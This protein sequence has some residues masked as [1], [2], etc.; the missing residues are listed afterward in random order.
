MMYL[1]AHSHGH[2]KAPHFRLLLAAGRLAPVFERARYIVMAAC[3]YNGLWSKLLYSG[4]ETWFGPQHLGCWDQ[5]TYA[6]QIHMQRLFGERC[7]IKHID[8]VIR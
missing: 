4:F 1:C 3:K 8:C 2:A 7:Y 6:S 5:N